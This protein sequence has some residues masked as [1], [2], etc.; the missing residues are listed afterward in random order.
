MDPPAIS[1]KINFKKGAGLDFGSC[2]SSVFKQFA[3][4]LSISY[5]LPLL[6]NPSVLLSFL[7]L[8]PPVLPDKPVIMGQ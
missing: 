1:D 4:S 8:F 5:S 6:M 3:T 7:L 2:F